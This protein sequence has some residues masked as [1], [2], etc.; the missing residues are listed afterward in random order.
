MIKKN[1]FE[2]LTLFSAGSSLKIFITDKSL[3]TEQ[4]GAGTLFESRNLLSCDKKMIK[5]QVFLPKKMIVCGA[6]IIFFAET[7]DFFV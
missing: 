4:P 6:D 5:T 3:Q 1:A 2:T 7:S